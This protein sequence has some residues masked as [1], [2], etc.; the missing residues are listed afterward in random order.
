MNKIT[1]PEFGTLRV[2][3]I[4]DPEDERP[5]YVVNAQDFSN[6][7]SL[8][9]YELLIKCVQVLRGVVFLEGVYLTKKDIH[10]LIHDYWTGYDGVL[11]NG[12]INQKALEVEKWILSEIYN[13][14]SKYSPNPSP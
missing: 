8:D 5:E 12:K 7:L 13:V 14:D 11:P 2:F 10:D 4:S 1:H 9:E 3:D 6:I